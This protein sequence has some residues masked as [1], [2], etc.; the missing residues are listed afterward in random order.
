MFKIPFKFQF[1]NFYTFLTTTD[2]MM[3]Y[4]LKLKLFQ[5]DV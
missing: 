2:L 5:I 1:D 4:K 3:F